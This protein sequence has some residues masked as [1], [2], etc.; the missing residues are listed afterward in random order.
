MKNFFER[1]G[2]I[3]SSRLILLVALFIMAFGNMAFFSNVTNAYPVNLKTLPF[4]GSL[5]IVFGGAIVLLLS[6]VCSRRTI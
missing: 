4:L 2:V 6:L 5:A 3:T 1:I